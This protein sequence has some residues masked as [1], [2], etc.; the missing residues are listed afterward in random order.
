MSKA[1]TLWDAAPCQSVVRS[2]LS[3]CGGFKRTVIEEDWN[4]RGLF[5]KY[6]RLAFARVAGPSTRYVV[7][8]TL[9]II[10]LKLSLLYALDDF[11]KLQHVVAGIY[12]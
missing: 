8:A 1:S 9:N 5:R 2:G 3:V 10:S 11:I 12:L 6:G 4:S 7:S